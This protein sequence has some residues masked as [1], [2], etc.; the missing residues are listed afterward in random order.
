M[1]DARGKSREAPDAST[2][3]MCPARFTNLQFQRAVRV[4]SRY[5]VPCRCLSIARSNGRNCAPSCMRQAFGKQGEVQWRSERRLITG[6]EGCPDQ[7]PMHVV[8]H[9]A[10][11]KP[12]IMR[13]LA[14][15]RKEAQVTAP[16]TGGDRS[17]I[18][19]LLPPIGLPPSVHQ[20]DH[21]YPA[22]RISAVIVALVFELLMK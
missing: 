9:P 12:S 7:G 6:G 19:G 2:K 21:S 4:C 20:S 3:A 13:R 17:D 8:I 14:C 10:D 11:A 18:P 16:C 5:R 22:Q 1:S 15:C